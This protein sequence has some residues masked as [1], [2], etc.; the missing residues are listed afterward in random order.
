MGTGTTIQL[1]KCFGWSGPSKKIK[2]AR[3]KPVEPLV[4]GR[5]IRYKKTYTNNWI[6]GMWE[7]RELI[8]TL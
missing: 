8:R 3:Q 4:L 5:K 1:K 2:H 6:V 7:E